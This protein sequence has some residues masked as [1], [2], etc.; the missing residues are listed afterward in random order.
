MGSG[1]QLLRRR[2]A[3][4]RSTAMGAE[5]FSEKGCGPARLVVVDDHDL[6]REGLR[7]ILA[8]E[9]DMEVVS[10]ATNGREAVALCSRLQP[11]LVLMDVRM[12]QMDGLAATREIKQRF[13]GISVM[14]VTMH[15][16]PDYLLEALRAG[17][18][19]YILK[20]ALQHEVVAAIRQ[21]LS[22]ESPL[23][24]ELA[25]RLLL[26]LAAE[27]EEQGKSSLR[28]PRGRG[29]PL[30]EP[31]TPRELE[32]LGFLKLGW[33][34][35]QIARELVISPGTVKNHVEHIIQKLEASDRTQAVVRALEL[36]ILD[37]ST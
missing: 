17:A 8:D 14:M 16:N 25:A 12:P 7:D 30:I 27:S 2:S 35:R 6:A 31:L 24:P 29:E 10:E 28:R 11:D 26:R 4:G 15:E 36:G 22:G 23:D 34:N 5:V 1:G 32:V 33:T 13:P 21:V 20:D 19:G 9:P 18:A 3:I 37:L